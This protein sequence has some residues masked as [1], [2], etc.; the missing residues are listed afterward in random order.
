MVVNGRIAIIISQLY[1]SSFYSSPIR[2]K[3][4]LQLIGSWLR[5]YLVYNYKELSLVQHNYRVFTKSLFFK[6]ENYCKCTCGYIQLEENY[7][8]TNFI[9][10]I[11][12]YWLD[13]W[14]NYTTILCTLW[15]VAKI[16][17]ISLPRIRFIFWGDPLQLV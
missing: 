12:N 13:N 10:H 1:Y 4:R 9:D 11:T 2:S 6:N 17:Q 7:P 16:N 14:I 15:D 5:S 3:F 8:K